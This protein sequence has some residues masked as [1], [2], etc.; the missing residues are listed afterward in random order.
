MT[1]Y[2]LRCH[3]R[4]DDAKLASQKLLLQHLTRIYALLRVAYAFRLT[5]RLVVVKCWFIASAFPLLCGRLNTR[6][7][8]TLVCTYRDRKLRYRT[9]ARVILLQI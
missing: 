5:Q 6:P 2:Q 7:P 9:W 4:D 3:G 1:S 8:R